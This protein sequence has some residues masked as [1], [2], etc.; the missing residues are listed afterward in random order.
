VV[1]G[2]L[3]ARQAT[4]RTLVPAL[5]AGSAHATRP[6]RSR[7]RHWI[8]IPQIGLS[9]VLLLVAGTLVRS[10][11][12]ADAV[13]PGYDASGVVV[14]DFDLPDPVRV[15]TGGVAPGGVLSLN[16][17]LPDTERRSDLR[18]RLL[19]RV[20]RVQ[21]VEAAS[22]IEPA[23]MQRLPIDVMSVMWV[24]A[25]EAFP[26][27]PR[28]WMG[29]SRG[30]VDFFR[31]LR[32]PLRQGRLFDARDRANAPRVAIVSETA[33]RLL[34]PDR[35]AVGQYVAEN[36]AESTRPPEWLEV[37]GVVGDVVSPLSPDWHPIV[38][39]PFEQQTAFPTFSVMVRTSG[40]AGE[41]LAR[42]RQELATPDLGVNVIGGR[43]FDDILA[44]IL[45]PRRMA[46]G[47]LALSG[48]VGLV[49]ASIGLYGV[50]SYSVA[51]REREVGIR[52]ALG[53]SRGAI[54]GWIL[55]EGA[56]VVALGAL[57]GAAL[58]FG[59]TRLAAWLVAPL[60]AFDAATVGVVSV[61]VAAVVLL[62]CYLPARRA[63]RVDPV[64]VLRAA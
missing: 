21:D 5:S 6:A 16:F 1:F 2:L 13:D 12:R 45:Y 24:I 52:A 14:V 54:V 39:T 38:Y 34:W 42:L 35:P 4:R 49:L 62:A 44:S 25:R 27:G 32:I 43:S 23:I 63:A 37:V 29:R 36:R 58:T 51:Q 15:D 55:R 40:S 10:L 8:V 59:A 17:D 46:A 22:L 48:I 53:A 50:I 31:T 26:R 33:A 60:P 20:R 57:A 18:R 30:S 11:L 41:T 9:V 19:D 61:V 3:P 7:L 56:L 47:I 28:H 64:E